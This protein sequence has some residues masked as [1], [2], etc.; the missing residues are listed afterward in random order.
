MVTRPLKETFSSKYIRLFYFF[1][2]FFTL[3]KT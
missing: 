2:N 1:W 3:D